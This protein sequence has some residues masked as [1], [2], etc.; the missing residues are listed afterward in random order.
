M[1][2]IYEFRIQEKLAN[3]FLPAGKG[4]TLGGWIRVVHVDR[5][6]PLLQK[7]GQF[8]FQM[9]HQKRAFFLSWDIRRE[10]SPEEISNAEWF[11]FLVDAA[12]ED[13]N[14]VCEYDDSNSC[15]FCGAG[16][17]LR[18][19]LIL[20]RAMRKD[21]DVARTLEGEL[22]VSAKFAALL[23]ASRISGYELKPVHMASKR[24]TKETGDFF[25][26]RVAGG[27]F[28]IVSPTEFG[29][30]PFDPDIEGEYRCRLGHIYGLNVLSEIHFRPP[31][32][33]NLPDIMHSTGF[34]GDRRGELRPNHLIVVSARL[35]KPLREAKI[36]VSFEVAHRA[37]STRET[38]NARETAF[39]SG[40]PE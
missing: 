32:G 24:S 29:I 8:E 23:R 31:L 1:R 17:I 26:L 12:L 4:R 6:D 15:Q 30:D 3:E 36:R 10:Y 11:Q 7:I 33:D 13:E 37:L 39:Q 2:E 34:V 25:H 22:V 16:G 40:V 5:S 9:K 19:P 20:K 18:P 21:I 28:E 27:P 38:R 14:V 35:A